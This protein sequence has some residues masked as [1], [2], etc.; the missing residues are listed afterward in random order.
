MIYALLDLSS[1][2]TEVITAIGVGATSLI[3]GFVAVVLS[4]LKLV[5]VKNELLETQQRAEIEKVKLEAEKLHLEN[6]LIC[7]TYT[8]CPNCG[9]K[10]LLTDLIFE[11]DYSKKEVKK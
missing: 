10:L 6:Q 4:R 5:K 1:F 8:I 7:G 2:S 9:S 3:T 11:N